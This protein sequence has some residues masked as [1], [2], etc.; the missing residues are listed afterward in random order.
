M[1][2]YGVFKGAKELRALGRI[3]RTPRL[4]CVQQETCAPMVSAWKDGVDRIRAEHVVERP[5]GIA[6]AILR[7]NP[8]R[9][10]PHVRR[11]VVASGG[12]FVA[13]SER[14]IRQ[15]REWVE[16]LEGISPCFSAAA[17]VAGLAKLRREGD[18]PAEDTVLVNLTG[19]DRRQPASVEGARRLNRENGGWVLEES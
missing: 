9:A 5:L 14:E 16:D 17:A 13:V 3:G 19:S 11:I 6:S 8:S 18:V 7:G 15:A 1:G 12:A 2:V 4:L 10:Y